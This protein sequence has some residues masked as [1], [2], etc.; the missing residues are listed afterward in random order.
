MIKDLLTRTVVKYGGSEDTAERLFRHG[1]KQCLTWVVNDIVDKT[2]VYDS[3][4][5]LSELLSMPLTNIRYAYFSAAVMTRSELAAL[6]EYDFIMQ[7]LMKL[8]NSPAL[9]HSLQRYCF[10]IL[11][12]IAI[13]ELVARDLTALDI[14]DKVKASNGLVYNVRSEYIKQML[15]QKGKL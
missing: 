12:R 4:H 3:I 13:E 14:M 10:R 7:T 6:P 8:H 9:W 2:C 11:K 15:E 5:A 1:E